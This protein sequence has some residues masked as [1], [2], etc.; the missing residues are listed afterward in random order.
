[1]FWWGGVEILWY[2]GLTLEAFACAASAGVGFLPGFLGIGASILF[3]YLSLS[4]SISCARIKWWEMKQ[5]WYTYYSKREQTRA[6]WEMNETNIIYHNATKGN[7]T[8][9]P[10]PNLLPHWQSVA[11]ENQLIIYYNATKGSS[12]S[13]PTIHPTLPIGIG[14]SLFWWARHVQKILKEEIAGW[15]AVKI[16]A[17]GSEGK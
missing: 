17:K 3:D 14:Q 12:T 5:I 9:P 7:N 13:P 16:V 1:M 6:L 11:D 4:V 10:S 2:G 15:H 8:P